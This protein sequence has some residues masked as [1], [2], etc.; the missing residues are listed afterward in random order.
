MSVSRARIRLDCA[1]ITSM[2]PGTPCERRR[3]GRLA[4]AG[5]GGVAEP[6][7]QRVGELERSRRI[8]GE[9]A[10]EG[11]PAPVE[12]VLGDDQE[13]LRRHELGARAGYIDRGAHAR[14]LL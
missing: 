6:R 13:T 10:G 7:S 11:D 2:L 9:G 3:H 4:V 1:S 5:D 8:D 14:P 12:L